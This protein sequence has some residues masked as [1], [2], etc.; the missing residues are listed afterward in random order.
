[1]NK[2]SNIAACM[3]GPPP[4][5]SHAGVKVP[6]L[7]HRETGKVR[8]RVQRAVTWPATPRPIRRRG[9]GAFRWG[10]TASRPF[11]AQDDF[12]ERDPTVYLVGERKG[13]K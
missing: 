12:T 7:W 9:I 1:M 2:K 13:K 11:Q 3:E 8:A 4:C 10:K 6:V 5:G